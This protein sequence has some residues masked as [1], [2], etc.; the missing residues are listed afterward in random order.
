MKLV[1]VILYLVSISISVIAI[2]L[3][4]VSKEQQLVAVT[5]VMFVFIFVVLASVY[6]E[7]KDSTKRI[8]KLEE[9]LNIQK[10]LTHI[11]ATQKNQQYILDKLCA[12]RRK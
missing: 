10:Q 7:V 8:D 1:D 3:G 2:I 6:G 12:K 9:N 11:E 5:V 4:F